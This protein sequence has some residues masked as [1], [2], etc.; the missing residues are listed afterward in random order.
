MKYTTL[1]V[2]NVIIM[3]AMGMSGFFGFGSFV[4]GVSGNVNYGYI[5]GCFGFVAMILATHHMGKIIT[6]QKEDK[7]K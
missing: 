2:P 7:H 4:G 1:Q 3:F 5:A 6:K